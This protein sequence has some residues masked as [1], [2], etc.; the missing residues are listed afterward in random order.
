MGERSAGERDLVV[1]RVGALCVNLPETQV[2]LNDV[3]RQ[4]GILEAV[5]AEHGV[6]AAVEATSAPIPIVP[7]AE[8]ECERTEGRADA[9]KAV[10]LRGRSV[11]KRDALTRNADIELKILAH[12][13]ARLEIG[14]D[15]RLVMGLRDAAEDVVGGHACAESDVPWTRR[16]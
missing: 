4:I 7:T 11:R 1:D 8:I 15:R 3:D 12:V 2:L 9:G 5:G 14:S 16:R 10:N 6:E 13:V